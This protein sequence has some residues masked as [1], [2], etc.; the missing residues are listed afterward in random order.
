MPGLSQW[1]VRRP[2]AA[3][4]AYFVALL[5]V[6]GIGLNFGGTLN[7]SFDLPDTESTTAQ[8]LLSTLGNEDIDAQSSGATAKV[9]RATLATASSIYRDE[10]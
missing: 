6:I 5:A 7:D 3:L 2:V 4:I 10:G 1:A 9:V 8:E